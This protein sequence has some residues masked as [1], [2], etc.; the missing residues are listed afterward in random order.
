MVK[1]AM[2]G[3]GTPARKG[4]IMDV[5]LFSLVDEDAKSIAPGTFE[6]HWGI[7][8]FDG[9]PKYEL[10][11]SGKG[12]DKPLVPVED[13]KYLPKTWC[14][15]D[16]NAYNLDDL[17]DNID[18]ACSLSDCT[19]L[20]Y[21]SSCNHLTATGNV[22][23]AFNMYYQMH[24][25]KTWDCDFLGLGLITDEDPSDELCEFPVM[26]DTGDSTR[27]QPGSSRVLT[28]VAAAVLVMLVL[29]IL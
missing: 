14:I 7:F 9:R 20:G 5:Y 11:L 24:D 29:P 1:H 15:L 23:Y 12:N 4:V 13:V 8:E 17:P 10:D 26:I 27:L 2:S 16:P 28:R 18:Y 22:S 19:A 3:N 21:G 6:R 25:Q